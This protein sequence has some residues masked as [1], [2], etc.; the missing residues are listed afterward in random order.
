MPTTSR[1]PAG[2]ASASG[3]SWS[4]RRPAR[5]G[6]AGRASGASTSGA[7]TGSV[8]RASRSTSQPSPAVVDAATPARSSVTTR[9]A[10]LL[11]V[12]AILAASYAFPLRA[13]LDQRSQ[14]AAL[15][16]Q[17]DALTDEVADLEAARELWNDPAYVRAQARERLNYVLP[18]EVGIVVLGTE[19]TPP[20]EPVTGTL[21]PAATDGQPWW[22]TLVS[23]FVAVG[24]GPPGESV[25]GP[26]ADPEAGAESAGSE[27]G[28]PPGE[29]GMGE[30]DDADSG[31]GAGSP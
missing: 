19:S 20:E 30:A 3:P 5:N 17:R 6:S 24:A 25:A 31:G 16:E 22:S 2:R 13:W 9:A 23:A 8:R 12:L 7:T 10:V 29:D 27:D 15:S 18:G 4:R 21:V 1:G 11:S 14:L 28:N 26:G